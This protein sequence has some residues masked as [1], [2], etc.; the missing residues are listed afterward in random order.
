MRDI[1]FRGKR[2]D[3][4]EWVYGT[5]HYAADNSIHYIL[6]RERFLNRVDD[7]EYSLHQKEVWQ[8]APS[9]VGQYTGVQ[10]IYEGDIWTDDGFMGIVVFNNS[11]FCIKWE[12]G[13]LGDLHAN[14][15]TTMDGRIIG[16]IHDNS[17]ILNWKHETKNSNESDVR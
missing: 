7:K 16:N 8:V 14:V 6:A 4:G 17:K 3:N 11:R 9:T 1:K 2:V 15:T 12:N 10:D 13:S 5:Y